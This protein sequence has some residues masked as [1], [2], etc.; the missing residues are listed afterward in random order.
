[1]VTVIVIAMLSSVAIPS[2]IRAIERGHWRAARDVLE[3]TYAGETVYGTV[4]GSNYYSVSGGGDW[5][6]IYMDDPNPPNGPFPSTLTFSVSGAANTFSATANQ[7]GGG[8]GAW[9]LSLD[10]A[11]TW[12]GSTAPGGAPSEASVCP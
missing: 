6:P 12:G 10:Q 8:C 11:H 7:S 9:N 2:Y 1:M 3:T 4:N 5:R